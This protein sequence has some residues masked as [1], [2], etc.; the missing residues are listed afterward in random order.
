MLL[1]S[2]GESE[3]QTSETSRSLPII[4]LPLPMSSF[5]I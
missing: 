1:Y 4:Y 3:P 2:A 5:M